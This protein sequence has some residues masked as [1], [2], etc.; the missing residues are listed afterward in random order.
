MAYGSI[1]YLDCA[2]SLK[3]LLE[4]LSF[5]NYLSLYFDNVSHFAQILVHVV[6]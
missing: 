4:M 2:S 3:T 5:F 6:S 1:Y